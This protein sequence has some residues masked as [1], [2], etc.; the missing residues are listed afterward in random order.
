MGS[1]GIFFNLMDLLGFDGIFEGFFGI[2][3][4]FMDL[5]GFRKDF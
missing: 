3:S 1:Y 2:F 4:S 5:V